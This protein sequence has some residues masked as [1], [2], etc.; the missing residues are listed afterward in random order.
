[1]ELN[2]IEILEMT[3]EDVE[4][5]KEELETEFDDF[6]NYNILKSEIENP[7]SRYYVSKINNEI[8]GF[9]GILLILDEAEIMN[10]VVRKSYRGMRNI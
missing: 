5:I 4:E 7:K 8:V 6:W 2:K 1:M 9:A 3:K 10:I